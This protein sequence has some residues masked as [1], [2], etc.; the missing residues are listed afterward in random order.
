MVDLEHP[1]WCDRTHCTATRPR[2]EYRAGETGYH[3]SAPV[4]VDHV[5]NLGDR[6]FDPDLNPLL[7]HLAQPA[8]PWD[9]VTLL[10]IGTVAEPNLLSLTVTRA[11]ATLHQLDALLALAAAEEP[12]ARADP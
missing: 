6:V 10:N 8:P 4:A 2:P 7:A 1:G 9:P 5:P 11:R 12:P 3:R